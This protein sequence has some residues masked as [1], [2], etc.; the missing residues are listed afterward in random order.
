MDR[1]MLANYREMHRNAHFPG[2]TTLRFSRDIAE[3]VIKHDAQTLL[4]Y[5]SGKGHQYLEARVHAAWGNILPFCFD[6]G[7]VGLDRLPSGFFDGCLCVDVL[8]H[9]EEPDLELVLTTLTGRAKKFLF[10]TVCTRAANKTLPDGRNCHVTIRP[11]EWWWE[12]I[13]SAVK[14]RDFARDEDGKKV[15]GP[16]DVQLRENP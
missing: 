5:G 7:V 4:D 9:V 13:E 8:E 2:Y 16:L 11:L 1:K 10:V 12:R 6:P 14:V 3:L 15:F